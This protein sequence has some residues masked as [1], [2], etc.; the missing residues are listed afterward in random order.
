MDNSSASDFGRDHGLIHEAVVTGRRAGWGSDEW[1]RLAHDAGLM[2]KLRQVLI[3]Q[4]IITVSEHRIN[5]DADPFIPDGWKVEEHRK[6]GEF[7][8]TPAQVKLHLSK[9]QQDR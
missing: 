9:K 3:G 4:A 5:L 7:K 2:R 8:W 1:A 6:S